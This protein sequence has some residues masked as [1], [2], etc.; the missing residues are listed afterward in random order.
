MKKSYLAIAVASLLSY[1]SFSQAQS[2][3]SDEMD[4]IVVLG[5]SEN[6]NSISDIP[7]NIVVIDQEEIKVSGTTTLSSLLRSRAGIQVSD[8]NSGPVFSLRGF[9]GE[10]AAHNTLI[11]VDGRKLNKPDLSAPQLSSILV[12]QIEKI[13]ILSGSAG[14][15][16]GD[17]AVGGVINIITK[18]STEPHGEVSGSVGSYDSFSGSLNVSNR[19]SDNWSFLLT[20]S[21]DNSDNYRDHNGRE[22]GMVL[23]RLDFEN[24]GKTFYTEVSYYDN[25]RK[26]AGSL[27][28]SQYTTDPTQAN[29]SYPNDYDHEITRA[30]RVGYK[31]ELSSEWLAK[32]DVSYDDTTTGGLSYSSPVEKDSGQLELLLH[33]ERAFATAAG[34]GNVLFG[35]GYN[36]SDFDYLS[37]YLDRE[38]VQE[39]SSF[40]TQLNYPVSD[41]ATIVTGG[42]YSKVEDDIK[43]K[44]TYSDG[45]ALTKDATAFELGIN[46]KPN[47]NIRM[48]IRGETNFRYAKVDEQAYTSS[49]VYGLKPQ[50]GVSAEAGINY[51]ADEY[52]VKV[53]IY[54]LKLKDEIIY[55]SSASAPTGVSYS[56]ANV[57]AD[58]S[59]RFGGSIYVDK[60]VT[61]NILLGAEYNYIDAQFTE[62]DNEGNELPWVAKHS[63]RV[64][65]N[66]DIVAD[67]QLLAEAAYVGKKYQDGD[68]GNT[69]EQLNDYWL[70]NF[71]VNYTYQ[72]FSANLR[73]DNMFDKKYADYVYYNGYT[74]GYYSGNGR[75]FKLTASY[76]F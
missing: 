45:D 46:F 42:R 29:T 66:Y 73:I 55:D 27:T 38:N 28:E 34:K 67:W 39:V 74:T 47:N 1:T 6:V 68:S 56:G 72:M 15:L 30:F 20:A 51:L 58:E 32:G 10:Q 3:S 71:A 40:Y 4:T 75:E 21:Q 53:D 41:S 8:S 36:R 12:S 61:N 70:S 60:Y 11:L 44:T 57:N 23:G 65:L 64:F 33:L 14:V 69:E 25:Y 17:Q 18:R 26:Y 62:G 13:E 43:D 31:Q 24:A 59:E 52:T 76:Q 49:D 9:T 54:D 16:Y 19:I 2:V 48:Y 63:G 35:L 7:A 37:S 50:K 22:T 5:K